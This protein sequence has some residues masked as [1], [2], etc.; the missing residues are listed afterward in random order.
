MQLHIIPI[1]NDDMQLHII[2]IMNDDKPQ[3][4]KVHCQSMEYKKAQDTIC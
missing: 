3:T 2:R 4:V 1:M